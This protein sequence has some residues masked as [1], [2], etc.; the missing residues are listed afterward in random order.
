MSN[1]AR[2]V[3]TSSEVSGVLAQ[4]ANV[5]PHTPDIEGNRQILTQ[6]ANHLPPSAHLEADMRHVINSRLQ[7]RASPYLW[8][9]SRPI[10][11]HPL[12]RSYSD[13]D[14]VVLCRFC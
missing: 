8:Y 6:A 3:Q 13:L 11:S 14:V 5:L 7:R 10:P 12:P 2:A 9:G 4:N 1:F